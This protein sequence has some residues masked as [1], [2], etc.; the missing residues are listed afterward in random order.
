MRIILT[1][2]TG[3]V[4]GETL[5]QLLA[6]ER[7][8]GV[9]CI[10]RRPVGVDHPKLAT[11]IHPDFT[12]WPRA[13]MKTLLM[14]DAAIW[15]L[16][17]K[18][19]DVS[20]PAEYE[21]VTVKSTLAFASSMSDSLDHV[22]R[23]CYLSGMG[24][25]P[26]ETSTF[27]WQKSTRH[28]KGRT[29]RGLADL[30]DTGGNFRASAF[31]PGGILPTTAGWLLNAILAPIAVRVDQLSRAMIAEA[32]YDDIPAFR[33]ISNAAIRAVSEDRSS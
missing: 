30:A 26:A 25:D 14:H 19:S 12:T 5:T 1:G 29:E 27:P 7:V 20:D 24:A 16:G 33:V 32:I 13:Q 23:F 28:L 9:T 31:R 17:V 15:A 6:D 8:N 2:A 3:F 11:I 21:R 10:S 18:A 22:F 4:G